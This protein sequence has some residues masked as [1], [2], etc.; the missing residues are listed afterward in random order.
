MNSATS[1]RNK[2]VRRAHIADVT[3]AATKDYVYHIQVFH[4][5]GPE[6]DSSIHH[7][8][9]D[10]FDLHMQLIGHFPEEAGVGGSAAHARADSADVDMPGGWNSAAAAVTSKAK[11]IIPELPGQMMFVSEAAAKARIAGLQSYIQAI[12]ALPPKIARSPVTMSFF[13]ADGKHALM[14]AAPAPVAAGGDH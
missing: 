4:S 14:N 6:P 3:R 9:D 7:T 12:L 13:R 10:F 2:P 1:N 11:R 8:Y 5:D